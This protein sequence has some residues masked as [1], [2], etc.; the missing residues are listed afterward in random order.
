MQ[1]SLSPVI[2]VITREEVEAV[3]IS[4]AIEVLKTLIES[5][6]RA[7]NFFEVVDIAFHGYNETAEELFEIPAVRN[8][9]FELDDKFPYWLYFLTK[10][11][12]GLQCIAYCFLPPF[13]TPQARAQVFPER[14][15]DLLTR[16][17]FPA[18]NEVCEW[19]GFTEQEIESLT[20]RSVEYLLGGPLDA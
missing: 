2:I 4:S 3:D 10:T 5:P 9:V 6:E 8:Y 11:G 7:L 20:D 15:N 18:M 14:L 16:R 1:S 19:T 12:T 13:L 17:W